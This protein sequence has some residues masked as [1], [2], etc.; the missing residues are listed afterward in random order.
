MHTVIQYPNCEELFS[1]DKKYLTSEI[2][3]LLL[4]E[5]FDLCPNWKHTSYLLNSYHF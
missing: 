5:I 1:I 2:T 3:E 4:K